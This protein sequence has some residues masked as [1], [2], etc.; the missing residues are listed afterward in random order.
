MPLSGRPHKR[1]RTAGPGTPV[2][3]P[4]V[5]PD[6]G[7]MFGVFSGSILDAAMRRPTVLVVED[8]HWADEDSRRVLEYLVRSLRTELSP[9]C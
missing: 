9:W 2:E 4:P 6:R 5:G 7:R 3:A 1:P 8:V